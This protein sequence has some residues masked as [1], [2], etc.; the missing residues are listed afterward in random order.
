MRG[1]ALDPMITKPYR[2]DLQERWFRHP[3]VLRRHKEAR[4]F[5]GKVAELQCA[6]WFAES[7]WTVSEL[8]ALGGECDIV[9]IS[10]EQDR[11]GIEVK[12][13]GEL[14]ASFCSTVRSLTNG[15]STF[16]TTPA[17]SANYLLF[18]IY[19]GACQ[20]RSYNGR[21]MVVLFV[22]HSGWALVE[23]E[24]KQDWMNLTAPGFLCADVEWSNFLQTQK[25]K[26]RYAG[27]GSDLA[28][29]IGTLSE[30]RVLHRLDN[31]DIVQEHVFRP[32]KVSQ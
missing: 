4:R 25:R 2:V 31:G 3:S 22:D 6:T 24:L 14:D 26:K 8:E 19:E 28:E 30:V 27:I 18:R 17:A 16:F 12:F 29:R 7:G 11:Y 32:G 9:A 20:L 10:P 5:H 15:A 1:D 13:L 23:R 21:A